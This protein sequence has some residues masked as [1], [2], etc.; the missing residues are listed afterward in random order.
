MVA[1]F[2][3]VGCGS[4]NVEAADAGTDAFVVLRPDGARPPTI[5]IQ[6]PTV[7]FGD[8]VSGTTSAAV[9]LTIVNYGGAVAR[10]PVLTIAGT[11]ASAFSVV[12]T[13]CG[14]LAVGAAC[15][16][17]VVFAPTTEGPFSAMLTAT[18]GPAA[19]MAG[20]T[21]HGIAAEPGFD[22]SPTPAD[23]GQ[24]AFGVS[25]PR[26]FTVRSHAS[27]A[28]GPF[29]SSIGG[30]DATQFRIVDDRCAGTML[31]PGAACEIDVGYA[32]TS[33]G[34]HAAS[35]AVSATVGGAASASLVGRC[36][37]AALL[38]LVPVTRDFGFVAIPGSS[39]PVTL[40]VDNVGGVPAVIDSVATHGADASEFVVTTD[41]CTGTLAAGA[42][43]TVEVTFTPTTAG[44]KSAT[45][46]V[47]AGALMTS[48][49][50]TGTAA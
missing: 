12:P 26:T 40:T 6:P 25:T 42:T 4:G 48:S 37:A 45:L 14:D 13:T 2:A 39:T 9:D 22:V 30:L 18:S 35:L 49:T 33:P 44:T 5:S 24:G 10:A 19:A 1:V 27:I 29:T 15:T 38:R 34:D 23:F 46:D 11:G 3:L 7:D 41:G 47:G 43:C 32:P 8:I 16:A 17:R 20:L 31:A 36:C 50:L 21:G 28:I